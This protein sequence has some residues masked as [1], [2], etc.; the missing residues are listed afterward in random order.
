MNKG[1]DRGLI[2]IFS[3]LLCIVVFHLGCGRK[4]A[5]VP[6]G[7]VIPPVVDDLSSSIDGN[8]LELAWTIP[9]EKGKIV[10]DL[11]G[12]IVYKSKTSLSESDCKGCPVLFKRIADIP[13]KEKDI[14]KKITYNETLEKGYR[15]IYKVTVYTKTGAS[16]KDSNYIEFDH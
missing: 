14:N 8:I 1:F 2:A 4:A 10:S 9:D 13:I 16:G 5:P 3:I 7:Q 15:Y 12:F 11:G 6:P